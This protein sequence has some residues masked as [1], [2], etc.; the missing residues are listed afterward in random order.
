MKLSKIVC[1][2][3]CLSFFT[4]CVD[5]N[6]STSSNSSIES[7][8]QNITQDSRIVATSVATLNICNLLDVELVGAPSS[9][10][11]DIP[12]KY[13]DLP[14]IGNSM[15]V[16]IEVLSTLNADLVISPKSLE[17]DL[18]PKYEALGVDYLF[19]DLTSIDSLYQSIID[20]GYLFD[21]EEVSNALVD[22]YELF[23]ESIHIQEEKPTVLVLMG[24]PGSYVVA[25]NKSYVGSL[26]ALS[27]FENVYGDY[28]ESFLN[29]NVEDML[30]QEPD[31][32]F[33]TA[34]AMP[35][36][37]SQMFIDEF[38]DNAVWKTFKAVQ[39]GNVVELDHNYFGMSANF[40]YP[41]AI[42]ILVNIIES[43]D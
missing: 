33:T 43:G 7:L 37:V 28:D 21:N 23:K 2:G 34:H 31:Y 42:G 12:E 35:E 32:I 16:D 30:L 6:Q 27:G 1:L 14:I 15:A 10:S 24:L 38:N 20:L 39:A 13:Q 17:N 3:L 9:D 11:Y 19:I 25:T 41:E 22:E 5:Q 40:S 18:M 8:K 26:V 29:V 36:M 4:G